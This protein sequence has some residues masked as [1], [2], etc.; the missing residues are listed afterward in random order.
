MYKAHACLKVTQY[1]PHQCNTYDDSIE[2]YEISRDIL[3][4]RYLYK[5]TLRRNADKDDI[6]L[7]YRCKLKIFITWIQRAD[8]G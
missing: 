8:I 7:R 5:I 4:V 6:I 2:R 3:L 1:V